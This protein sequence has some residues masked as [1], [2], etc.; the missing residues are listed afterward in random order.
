GRRSGHSPHPSAP[1]SPS[2]LPPTSR[3]RAQPGRG[4]P[5]AAS[6]ACAPARL[7]LRSASSRS[8]RSPAVD[9]PLQ[10]A[11][12]PRRSEARSEAGREPVPSRGR[13]DA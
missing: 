10:S 6:R 12:T 9:W 5:V 13:R 8:A 1:P 4:T 7:A 11:A 2:L 3:N